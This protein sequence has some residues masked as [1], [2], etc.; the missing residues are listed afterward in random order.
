MQDVC[1]FDDAEERGALLA[2]LKQLPIEYHK[3]YRRFNQ[4]VKVPRGQ[5]SFTL[6]AS[7][8][9]D[10]KVSGGSPPNAVMCDTLRRITARVNERLGTNFN[11]ILMNVYKD[12]EDCIGYHRDRETGWAP[13][14]G[15]ATLCFGAERDFLLKHEA[16]GEVTSVLHRCGHALHLPSPMNSEYL[17]AVPKRKRVKACRIS[18]TFREIVS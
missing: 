16:T 5:A 18:L 13:G 10:Y 17:H 3:Q 14:T 15:F 11:T 8:H 1:V 7:I 9:Y 12:G 4:T 2:Y 6:D